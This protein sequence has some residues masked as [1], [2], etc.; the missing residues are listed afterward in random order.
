MNTIMECER[1]Y[2]AQNYEPLPV[3]LVKGEGVYVWDD[4]GNRYIDMMSAYSAISHG[5]CHPYLV[6]VLTQQAKTLNVVSRAFYSD[7]LGRFLQKICETTGF[8]QALP[9]NTGA[10]A[11]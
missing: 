8:D 11:V 9:M 4:A 2:G 6:N 1:I 5:H 7:Q 3:V 10:E